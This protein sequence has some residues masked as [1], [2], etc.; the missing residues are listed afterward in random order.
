MHSHTH[1]LHRCTGWRGAEKTWMP[2]P[3]HAT[4]GAVFSNS[5]RKSDYCRSNVSFCPHSVVHWSILAMC[6]S[7][8]RKPNGGEWKWAA[9][10]WV[11]AATLEPLESIPNLTATFFAGTLKHKPLKFHQLL[12]LL[13][14]NFL[15]GEKYDLTIFLKIVLSAFLLYYK[16]A[17]F[18]VADMW[19]G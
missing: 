4:Q 5:E 15:D 10:Y 1:W 9:V 3:Y 13:Q 18:I 7:R 6:V 12:K 17:H 2:F 16:K 8:L 14:T 11:A 19:T